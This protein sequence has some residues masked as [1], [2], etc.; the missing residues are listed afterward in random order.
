[1]WP[2]YRQTFAF[3]QLGDTTGVVDV[4]M[5]DENFLERQF[6]FFDGGEDAREIATRVDDRRFLRGIAP[7][8]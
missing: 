6:M 3:S 2:F 5:R 4:A 7:Q 8:Q 1:M